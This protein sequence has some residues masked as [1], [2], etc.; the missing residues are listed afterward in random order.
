MAV[1]NADPEYRPVQFTI[2]D[3]LGLMV[4]VAVLGAASRFPVSLF[5]AIPLF[6]V[7][8]LVKFRILTLRVHPWL[9][10]LLYFATLAA[11]LPYLY[12]CIIDVSDCQGCD[13]LA[14]WIGG[15]ILAF[16]V[17]TAFFLYDT[18]AHKRPS[19]HSYAIRSLVEIVV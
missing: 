9:G 10:L 1:M 13:P 8:Y 12:Y 3:L 4:I 7:V 2:A 14:N 15:P 6:A 11:L 17:P 18:L 19:L 5:H 16:T